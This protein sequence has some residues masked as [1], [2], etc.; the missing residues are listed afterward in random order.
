MK[1]TKRFATYPKSLI[2]AGILAMVLMAPS[3]NAAGNLFGTIQGK[4][5]DP[6]GRP[7]AGALVVVATA[8][9]L[10]ADRYVFTDSTGAFSIENLI[11]GEYALQVTMRQF[12][13]W[14]SQR[15]RVGTSTLPPV[16]VSMQAAVELFR[17]AVNLDVKP[18]QDIVWTLR[19]S[20]STQPVLRF[21]DSAGGPFSRSIFSDYSGFLQVYSRADANLR[22]P[23]GVGSRFSVTRLLPGDA[24]VT[25]SGQYNESPSQ[26][27]GA[28]AIYEFTPTDHHRTQIGLNVRQ[29]VVLDDVFSAEELKEF[30]LRYADKFE[31]TDK[32]TLEHS[33]DVGHSE[34]KFSNNYVRPRLGVTWFVNS[35]TSLTAGAS[36]QAPGRDDDPIRGRDYFEQVYL[37]PSYEHYRHTEIGASR[38][39]AADTR[40]SAAVFE[41][42]ANFRAL[43][44]RADDG[45]RG[46]LI[47]DGKASPSRGF[48]LHM[49]HDFHGIEAGLG[50]TAAT[51]PGFS[52]SA[53][54]IED[55]RD[56][57]TDRRFHVVTARL[58]T[59]LDLTNTE[60]TAVYRWISKY[61]A[62]PIDPYQQFT[63]Y[64]DPTLSISVAQN[65][66]TWGT[67]PAKVQ[68]ILDARNLL[69]QSFGPSS[70][71]L[72]HS[73]RF[74][75]GGINI[76]F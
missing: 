73:P 27:K 7:L 70:A 74:L 71:H 55:V 53:S 15:I 67:F 47:F 26:P 2:A 51:G 16:V 38:S 37:P 35:K 75:K 50:Y 46:L 5:R 69:E 40:V 20:R 60:L 45:R 57:M 18:S 65:L 61:S 9:S 76:R 68:A 12:V 8:G 23:D 22:N 63:E 52:A 72:A 19:S 13:P 58:K 49:N 44:V 66:P 17:N 14:Q 30:Q 34:G 62:A 33:A 28:S 39:V 3:A 59:D 6:G 41:D 10:L 11:T 25:F 4:V 56:K 1:F 54:S 29:G 31:V 21:S 48:R 42:R 43:F 36:T 24:K 32:I 64:N